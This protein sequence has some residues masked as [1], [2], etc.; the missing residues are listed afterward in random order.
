MTELQW[1]PDRLGRLTVPQLACLG[2]PRPP[3]G[4]GPKTTWDEMKAA[5]D[6]MAAEAA[7]WSRS[8]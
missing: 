2:S 1:P 3:G 4:G 7:A 6:A 5:L 8:E